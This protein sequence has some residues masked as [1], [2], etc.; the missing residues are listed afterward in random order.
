MRYQCKAK[1]DVC[2]IANAVSLVSYLQVLFETL[3]ALL[4]SS[5]GVLKNHVCLFCL[6]LLIIIDKKP[7][8][9]I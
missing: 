6:N 8:S 4:Q 2:K 5:A 9:G 1:I 7:F 3:F